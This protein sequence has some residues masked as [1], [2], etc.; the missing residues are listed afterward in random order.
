M[1]VYPRARDLV[2]D[3]LNPSKAE[4]KERRSSIL[5]VYRQLGSDI[6]QHISNK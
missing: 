3:Y 5:E 4:L 2:N 6:Q 1:L